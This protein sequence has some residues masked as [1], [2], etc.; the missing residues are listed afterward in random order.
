VSKYDTTELQWDV[1]RYSS[2]LLVSI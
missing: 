1:A 2:E